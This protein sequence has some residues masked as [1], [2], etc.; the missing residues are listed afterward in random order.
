MTLDTNCQ[1]SCPSVPRSS[2]G[3][4]L[5]QG[6]S[7]ESGPEQPQGMFEDGSNPAPAFSGTQR[8][9]GAAATPYRGA[10]V[11]KGGALAFSWGSHSILTTLLCWKLLHGTPGSE[12]ARHV[13][14]KPRLWSHSDLVP[15]PRPRLMRHVTFPGDFLSLSLLP[16]EGTGLYF[17]GRGLKGTRAYTGTV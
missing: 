14:D 1:F 5:S 6:P 2:W 3:V 10:P 7:P 12:I 8:V 17:S 15:I 11:C 16:W 9:G 13:R 4:R